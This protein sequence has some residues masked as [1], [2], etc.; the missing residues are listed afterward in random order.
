MNLL[1]L[2]EHID[3]AETFEAGDIIFT[4]GETGDRMYDVLEGE[5]DIQVDGQTV[6][7]RAIGIGIRGRA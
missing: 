6:D 4:E 3:D 5:V 1:K 2:F 7:T